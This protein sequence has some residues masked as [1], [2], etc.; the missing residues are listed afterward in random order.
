MQAEVKQRLLNKMDRALEALKKD[1]AGIRT[2]RASLAIFDGINVDYYGVPT[3]INQVATMAIPESRLITIQPWEPKLISEIEKAIQKSDLG[4]NPTN[5]GKIIRIAIPQLTEE[6]RKQIIKHVHKRVEE[7]KIS[8]RNIRR[9]GNEEI[10][11]L[12]KEEHISK[13]ETRRVLDDIQ[14]LTDSY[15]KRTE[16]IMSH[17]EAE[18]M[19]V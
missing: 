3:P 12:E 19:E 15:I 6:R 2:G 7:A 18:L 17:K 10:K 1:L 13:D 9:E 11:K 4:L 5:D 14:K 16:E 8:T